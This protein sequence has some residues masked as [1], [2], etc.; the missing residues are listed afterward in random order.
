MFELKYFGTI[1]AHEA[2]EAAVK[3]PQ[4]LPPFNIE[5]LGV[6]TALSRAMRR[7]T[8]WFMLFAFAVLRRVWPVARIGRLV[9]VTRERDV[10]EVLE[11]DKR[12]PVPFGP[13]MKTITGGEIFALGLDGFDHKKQR[14]ILDEVVV[15]ADA[16]YIVRRTRYFAEAL[17]ANS[18]GRIDVMRDF[19]G[20]IFTETCSEYFGLD[21]DEPNAF[22]D[23]SMAISALLFADPMGS[24]A[25][26]DLA[27]HGAVRVRYLIDRAIARARTKPRKS[28]I[29]PVV[30]RLVHANKGQLTT[31]QIRAMVI[32]VMT[33][34]VPTN[35]LAAGKI[36]EELQRRG[37]LQSAIG[38][39]VAAE[40]THQKMLEDLRSQGLLHDPAKAPEVISKARRE[41]A[42]PHRQ[43][44]REILVE[45]ARLNPALLPGQFRHAPRATTIA[46]YD[47]PAGS[48]LVVSTASALRD[49]RRYPRPGHFEAGR[50]MG[51]LLMFGD[52]PHHCLGW[53][54]ALE[55]IT[56]IYQILLS[57]PNI[58]FSEHPEGWLSYVGPFPRRLDLEFDPPKWPSEQTLLTIA[59]AV[60]P[61]KVDVVQAAIKDLDN[62]APNGSAIRTALDNT[63]IVHFASMSVFNAADPDE[64][65]DKPNWRVVLELNVDGDKDTALHRI[66]E[67]AGAELRQ[68]FDHTLDSKK[69]DLAER[70]KDY[71]LELHSLPWGPIGLNFNGTP[72]TPVSDI[73]RQHDLVEFAR[74]SLDHYL[75]HRDGVNKRAMDA[76]TYVRDLTKPHAPWRLDQAEQGLH[77][78]GRTLREFLIRPTRRRLKVSEFTGC[79]SRLTWQGLGP[80]LRSNAGLFLGLLMATTFMVQGGAIYYA[81]KTTS[82]L[83]S[84]LAIAGVVASAV[85]IG[86]LFINHGF[87]R[88]LRAARVI[89]DGTITALTMAGFV[90]SAALFLA[91][92]VVRWLY[93]PAFFAAAAALSWWG[94]GRWLPDL[95]PGYDIVATVLG[96]VV[97]SA[98]ALF[99][100]A[101]TQR[102]WRLI[103]P[104]VGVAGVTLWALQR[105]LP[106]MPLVVDLVAAG[107]AGLVAAGLVRYQLARTRPYPPRFW[108]I[109]SWSLVS[110]VLAG[111]ALY[112]YLHWGIAKEVALA[113]IAWLGAL[114]LALVG[115][116]VATSL[117]WLTPLAVLLTL[118][119]WH[120]VR[121]K[122]DERTASLDHIES[123]ALKENAPGY[124]QNHI[125][126]VTPMK[127]GSFRKLSLALVLWGIG[128]EILYWFRP[129][130][131]LNM[132]TI[133][134]AKWFRLPRTEMMLFLANYDGSWQSYLEDF[135]T[136][137]HEG[138]SAVW[139]HGKGFP[140][141]RL[142][143]FGGAADG[144]RFKRWVRRQQIV[145]QFW[146]SRYPHLTTDQIRTNAMI[147]DGLMRAQTDT[148]ARAWLDLFGTIP[149][150]ENS[151]ES[152]EVQSLVFR[153]MAGHPHMICAA[154]TF[155]AEGD[156]QNWLRHLPNEM[157]Y[158]EQ[159]NIER[160]GVSYV[161]FSAAGIQ[162]CL[163]GLDREKAAATMQS[164]PPAFCLGMAR[165]SRVL[166]DRGTSDTKSWRWA[167]I[168]RVDDESE[169]GKRDPAVDVLVFAYGR[170]PEECQHVLKWHVDLLKPGKMRLVVTSPTAKTLA[171]GGARRP[172][173]YDEERPIYEHFGFRDGISQ[174]VIRGSQ[175][176]AKNVN[177]ADI[178]APGEMIL[179]YIN[180]GGYKAPAITLPAERDD[181]DDLETDTPDFAS[182]FPR[183]AESRDADR[184]DLGRNG[185]FLAVRQLAQD[186]DGFNEFLTH[187]VTQLKQYR[188]L[189]ATVGGK[190]D[191]EWVAA[192]MMGRW[193][194]GASLIRWP[195]A[196]AGRRPPKVP[197]NDFS[198]GQDDPQGL[199]CPFGAHIRRANPRGSLDPDDPQ[200]ADI[201]R[202]HRLL[203]RGRTYDEVI[204][205]ERER[206]LLFVGICAD[207]ERQ[208]EFLQ[209][210]WLG[211]PFF[212]GL[213]NEPDPFTTAPPDG[214]DDYVFTMP[215]PSGPVTMKGLTSFVT[216]KGGGYFFMPSRSAI[217]FLSRI[218][219]GSSAAQPASGQAGQTVPPSPPS[220]P[221]PPEGQ[222]APTVRAPD[223]E[224]EDA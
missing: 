164:F 43:A 40:K 76:L 179:G 183:F 106:Q 54:L 13:E 208:F 29:I 116:V 35:S 9:V 118:L 92:L 130:F 223:K 38:A 25:T 27:L 55:Q 139:S 153:G 26:R 151:I 7:L 157:T 5:A 140:R 105:W 218:A 206:G 100:I 46:G 114:S 1:A 51:P 196:I 22:L 187:Q 47:V 142:L 74:E 99:A 28:P 222:P 11:D 62:P 204:D 98:A 10:C 134:Y 86:V 66:A 37:L 170:T 12:F 90:V 143:I 121:D 89:Q 113:A 39:A 127:P 85:L 217:R 125:T 19:L 79:D 171:A 178:V 169:F 211:S 93:W 56:E 119:Y 15:Y 75:Q 104:L 176:A 115:G 221:P 177:E 192:K 202:R 158:G 63:G 148:S 41:T 128:K 189:Q 195:H 149:R 23:R 126:A 160:R 135:V 220:P 101:A 107:M 80:A 21:L 103:L 213:S 69:T 219:G 185:T 154:I 120:E 166:G 50:K 198:F 199:R 188:H 83:A 133:H 8:I 173:D 186:V 45:A 110:L 175:R 131:V 167:D 4:A 207:L 32:G 191:E 30:D 197:D 97:V 34:M 108:R 163:D 150:P 77:D 156:R 161:A 72:D 216:V 162:Q 24:K 16:D 57:Q 59:A 36:I 203:R 84:I 82:W 94:V 81:I 194:E 53:R 155:G 152:E 58:H 60:D 132:G 129:G 102:Y 172:S 209:Q 42:N 2:A 67:A 70:L 201:E 123:I 138:Q 112:S 61:E 184:R 14:D 117:V 181:D 52:G 224:R 141:T 73:E 20:R 180:S 205:C 33:G 109:V 193:R 96:T 215:T 65:D 146:Y 182:R 168:E 190:I 88:L 78:C 147:H 210:S 159:P 3:D 165:R 145:T 144:D 64:P 212:H 49:E 95:S 136:K 31:E 91:F 124:A 200:Q 17:L 87:E 48:V 122:S 6:D 68:I 71:S 44:L 214:N 174:P 18:G 111:V 137:A